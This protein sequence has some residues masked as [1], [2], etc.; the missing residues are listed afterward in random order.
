MYNVPIIPSNLTLVLSRRTI[1]NIFMGKI[2]LWNDS[3]ILADN[4]VNSPAVYKLLRNYGQSINVV[5]RSDSSG[6]SE[7]FS[8]ALWFFDPPGSMKKRKNHY[9]ILFHYPLIHSLSSKH[10]QCQCA[11]IT[12]CCTETAS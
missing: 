5:V 6:T 10:P 7:I 2:Q 12:K 8:T 4:I 3:A 9:S 11:H 1:V